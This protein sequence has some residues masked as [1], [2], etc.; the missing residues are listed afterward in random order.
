MCWHLNVLTYD[1]LYQM[2]CNTEFL[3]VSI[4]TVTEM[5]GHL[6]SFLV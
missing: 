6:T 1:R 5:T 3:Y 2:H 4:F